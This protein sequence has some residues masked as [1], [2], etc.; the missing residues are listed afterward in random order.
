[1][2]I[3]IAQQAP[4]QPPLSPEQ[5]E[6]LAQLRDIHEPAPLAWWPPAPGWW[7]LA[8]LVVAAV[9]LAALWIQH[10]RDRVRRGRYRQEAV[11]LLQ[12]V[13]IES[14]RATEELNEILKRVAVASYGRR[15]AGTL[16]GRQWLSFLEQSGGRPCPPMAQQ[17]LLE[18]LYRR[19]AFDADANSALQ[20]F[21]IDWARSHKT[22]ID[23][24]RSTNITEAQSV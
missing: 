3:P 12:E 4:A 15:R 1:M 19:D 21:A 13:D 20:Q 2:R 9:I 14:P 10:A 18:Q 24:A 16:T 17:A 6:L 23:D 11:R 8:A 5:Q 7:L 22:R